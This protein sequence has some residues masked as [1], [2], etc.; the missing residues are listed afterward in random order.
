[1]LGQTPTTVLSRSLLRRRDLRR[2]VSLAAVVECREVSQNVRVVDFS[3]SGLRIDQS[4]GLAVGDPVRISLSADLVLDGEVAWSVWHKAGIN[5]LP[6]L[7]E[8]HPAYVFLSEQAAT[9]ERT[10]MR[11]IATL[12]KERAGGGRSGP[13]AV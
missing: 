8:D 2:R 7:A 1:L 12:A 3:S 11:A 6:P 4:K 9:I 5:L 10:R 13:A